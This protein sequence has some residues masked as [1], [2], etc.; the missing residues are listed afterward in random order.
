MPQRAVSPTRKAS[1]RSSFIP[2]HLAFILGAAWSLQCAPGLAQSVAQAAPAAAAATSQQYRI[3]AGPLADVINQFASQAGIALTF[4]ADALQGARS[5]GVQGSYTVDDGLRQALAGSRWQ[6]RRMNNGAYVL[7]PAPAPATAADAGQGV[8]MAAVSV[9]A[10]QDPA[11]TEGSGTY[12]GSSSTIFKG[13]QSVRETPQPVTIVSRQLLDDRMLPDM[14]DVLQNVPGVTVDY[15]DS[16]RVTYFSRGYQIDSLQVDGINMYQSGSAFVQPDTAVLDRIEI[17]RG[18]SGILRGSGNPSATVNLVR[19]LPT[20]DFQASVTG[21]LGSWDR[22]RATAD[23]SGSF[24]DS[25]TLRGR[26]VAVTDDKD[27]FQDARDEHRRV[28]YGV[29]QADITDHTTV[30]ASF[31]H[32]QLKATGAWGGLPRDFDGSALDLGRSTYLGSDWNQWNRWNEQAMLSVETRFDNEWQL[33]ATAMNTRFRYFDG[34]FTQTYITRASKTNPYLFNVATSDY[35]NSASDQNAFALTAN[36]PFEAFGRKHHLTVGAESTYVRTTASSGMAS[37][38]TV[39]NIDIRDWDSYST[40]PEPTSYAGGSYY[41]ASNNVVKQ[42]ALYALGRFSLADPLTVMLG[43]RAT[44]YDYEVLQGTAK[45]RV[46]NEITPYGGV[47][48]DLNDTFSLYGSYSQIFQPQ[49]AYDSGGNLLDPIRGDDYEA[50]IKGEFFGGRLNTSLS[51]FQ[52]TNKGKAMDDASSPNPCLP[53]YPTGYCKVDG[54]KTRSRGW[55][56]EASGELTPD[57]QIMAGYTNTLTKYLKDSSAS[58]EG[59]PIRSLDPRHLVRIFTT[60]RLPGALHGLTVGAGVQAQSSIY[61]TGGGVTAKQG[62]YAIYNAMAAYDINKNVRLQL[63]VNNIFDKVYYKKVDATGIS[64][65]Y[66]DPRNAMLT[67]SWRM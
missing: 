51:L 60:Y 32:S 1:R 38:G 8:T 59:L 19:K 42:Q 12:G 64:N 65:Y 63:N 67:L 10:R 30:T 43:A 4:D 46:N 5:P 7:E 34:G 22:R 31:E 16:E 40:Y 20:R 23:I 6:P 3:A 24:N 57:W 53:N 49:Q 35:P 15:T 52:I 27:F 45:Y 9:T 26:I 36:G 14:H 55:E 33:K 2:K 28:F 17:L 66:G 48:Y 54:G 56:L 21:T 18:S 47:V 39:K 61:A 25:Q 62:G 58:N 29:L 50:G 41:E 11:T 13:A 37:Y 44:W